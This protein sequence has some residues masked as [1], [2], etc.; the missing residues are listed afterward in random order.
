MAG[1]QSHLC[2][3]QPQLERTSALALLMCFLARTNSVG[4]AWNPDAE[5]F[6]NSCGQFNLWSVS[7][8]E[9]QF[10][11]T[12]EGQ[13]AVA[14]RISSRATFAGLEAADSRLTCLLFNS[15]SFEFEGCLALGFPNLQCLRRPISFRICLVFRAWRSLGTRWLR[16]C[17]T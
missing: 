14:Q 13:D 17:I 4:R 2:S 15:F 5:A 6:R 9:V 3:V 12:W 10:R 16:G 8:A 1:Q 11:L 7:C